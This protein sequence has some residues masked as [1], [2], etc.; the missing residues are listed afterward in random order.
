MLE[1]PGLKDHHLAEYM[2]IK[3]FKNRPVLPDPLHVKAS[4]ISG[5]RKQRPE[6]KPQSKIASHYNGSMAEAFRKA[7]EKLNR[8]N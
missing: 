5:M 8:R 1:W 2:D 7:E 3:E 4:G 6:Q